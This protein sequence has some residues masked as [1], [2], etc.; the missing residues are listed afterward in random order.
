MSGV[1]SNTVSKICLELAAATRMLE[2]RGIL[3]YSGHI[4]CRVP[5][6]DD[7]L[8]QRRNDPRATLDPQRIVRVRPD[9]STVGNDGEPPSEVVIHLE[10]L[11]ARADVNSV[12]HCHMP[13]AVKFTL[14][15]DVQLA[16]LL[17][18]ATRWRSGIPTH[19]TPAHI[20]TVEQG[21]ALAQT[22]GTHNAALM[23]AHGMVLVSESVPGI[24]IDAVHFNEN[25]EAY[26]DVLRA[27]KAPAPLTAAEI[28]G[29]VKHERRGHHL[30][31]LFGYYLEKSRDTLPADWDIDSLGAASP[32]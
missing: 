17:C 28:E 24:F 27:G 13:S 22:L 31:K 3:N 18:H 30:R 1:S 16:P 32:G 4:S 21:R 6:S 9:G 14:M 2:Q 7:I 10:I 19:P 12:L 20:E 29:L 26:L 23:R 25:A 5:D 11:K 15:Q 8:I